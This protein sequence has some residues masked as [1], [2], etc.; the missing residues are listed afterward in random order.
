M[1]NFKKT[2]MVALL[3]GLGL[4]GTS[5]AALFNRGN[6]L[7]YDSTQNITWLQDAN[8]A[9]TSG[10]SSTGLMDWNAAT[11]WVANLVYQGYNDWRLPTT[12]DTGTLGCN[13]SYSGTDCGYNVDPASSELAHLYFTDLGNLSGFDTAGNLRSG[14]W[15]FVNSGPF[16]NTNMHNFRY[17]WSG[18]NYRT[19]FAWG[20]D[21]VYGGQ[22][23]YQKSNQLSAWAVRP[24]DVTTVPV[25]GAVWLYGSGLIGLLSFKRRKKI[26][27]KAIKIGI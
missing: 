11:T 10:D 25:S 18:S 5:Q 1:T 23:T 12:V 16:T 7:I 4:T 26:K 13:F 22:G 14:N 15:G 3:A 8:Y 20:F 24:G 2:A 9:K 27:P 21:S 17:Y 6:G 19:D